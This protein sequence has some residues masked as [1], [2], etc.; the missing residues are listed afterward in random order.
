MDLKSFLSKETNKKEY[1]W[2]LVIE[3]NWIQAG[4][5]TI[6]DGKASVVATS[7]PTAWGTDE[8]LISSAD[9]ALSSIV[10]NLPE[11]AQEPNKTVFGVS[12][13]WVSDGQI[14]K[15]F[16]DKLKM[17]C[18]ELSLQPTGFVTLPEAISHYVKTEEGSPLSAVLVGMTNEDL[19]VSVFKLGRLIGTSV[20]AR[21]VSV[22]DDVIEGLTRFA[23]DDNLPSRFILYDGKEGELEDARQSLLSSQ[24]DELEK[25]KFLHTPKV[26]LFNPEKKVIAVSLGGASEMGGITD[27][28]KDE[29]KETKQEEFKKEE[30][31]NVKTPDQP[32]S[33]QDVGFVVGEDI[34]A[35]GAE[36]KEPE[37]QTPQPQAQPQPEMGQT[38][39]AQAVQQG[40]SFN[41]GGFT[42][43]FKKLKISVT[44]FFAGKKLPDTG[45]KTFLFGGI[46]F[47][48]VLV[49]LFLL[50]WFVPKA[51]VTIFVSPKSLEDKVE[52]SVDTSANSIDFG[53][54]ILPGKV[55]STS[56]SGDKTKSTS[57][58]KTVG[59]R[60]KGT[61]QLRNGTSS[62]IRLSAGSSIFSNNLEFTL[63]SSASISAALSPGSPGTGTVDVT[64]SDIG[65]EYN[66]GKDETFSVS[67]Y[68]KAEVDAV[69]QDDFSGGSSR[70]I[71]AVSE[72]DQKTLLEDLT[73]ELTDKAKSDIMGKVAD[74]ETLIEGSLTATPSSK[75]YSSKVGDEAD[76]L[77]LSLKLDVEGVVVKKQDLFDLANDVLKNEIPSGFV[78][79]Q[80]QVTTDLSLT[81]SKNG[82]YQLQGTI[83]ANLLPEINTEDVKQNIKGKYTE[84]ADKY[85]R[86]IPSFARATIKLNPSL[87]GKLGS[88]PRLASHITI[89][90]QAEK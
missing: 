17:L 48:V 26:E 52:L 1:F 47:V 23:S 84:I 75:T 82:V 80:S 67:N 69:A 72:S 51:T 87:P 4:I 46:F 18:A 78:L 56:E 21:S 3:P 42:A 31:E 16:L 68:P 61:V 88:L 85:F 39:Q 40:R 34:A 6:T 10:S 64:A 65:A 20:V 62:P 83:G 33:A 43:F 12:S 59:E 32:I 36:P 5:W 50:W 7:N 13:T 63:D 41:M 54:K 30:V 70:Q 90:V 19:E 24:W 28:A 53:K 77:K 66:L 14:K 49:A 86:T 29:E 35:S 22:F 27:V 2:S 9:T 55:V 58:T 71:Q 11:D 25:I 44:S 81:G 73:A 57:G 60:A 8:E 15:E 45:G 76:T 89:E 37:P 79:R 38:P 74:D